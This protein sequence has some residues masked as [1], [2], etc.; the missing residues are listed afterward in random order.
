[1]TRRRPL[2]LSNSIANCE[3]IRSRSDATTF[4]AFSTVLLLIAK[5]VCTFPPPTANSAP[6][7]S[8]FQKYCGLKAVLA[9]TNLAAS[10]VRLHQ[11][12]FLSFRRQSL[13]PDF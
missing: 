5:F 8:L 2:N 13:Q 4:S 6:L 10:L 9:R 11:G 7:C 1:M 3:L 12:E